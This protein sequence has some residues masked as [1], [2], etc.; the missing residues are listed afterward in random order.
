MALIEEPLRRE[1]YEIADVVVSQYKRRSLLRVFVYHE[2][3]VTL[4]QCARL[5]DLIGDLIEPTEL[6]EG[7]YTLEVSSPGLDR[8]LR[9]VRDFRYRIGERVRVSF[10]DA[11]R[12]PLTAE[13]V[14]VTETAVELAEESGTTWVPIDEI[15]M[16]R[17]LF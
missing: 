2:G 3:G 16:A 11:S 7:G 8:P 4:D 6:F 9:T 12:R 17:I 5:S 14:G 15:E 13:I 10:V 1:G